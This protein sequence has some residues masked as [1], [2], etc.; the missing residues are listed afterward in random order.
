[1]LFYSRQ[2]LK[3]RLTAKYEDQL[4]FH[5]SLNRTRHSDLVTKKGAQLAQLIQHDHDV[6]TTSATYRTLVS[7]LC[8]K[9]LSCI[10]K[11]YL[12]Q[13]RMRQ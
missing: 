12:G 4:T 11:Q 13:H 6:L 1:M 3:Y 8:L 9:L 2:W 5:P 10:L 7:F